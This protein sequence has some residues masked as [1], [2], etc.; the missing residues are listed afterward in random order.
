MITHSLKACTPD[1]PPRN[2]NCLTWCSHLDRTFETISV[3]FRDAPTPVVFFMVAVRISSMDHS[4]N[5]PRFYRTQSATCVFR[6]AGMAAPM[7]EFINM[8]AAIHKDRPEGARS[9]NS[10]NHREAFTDYPEM[11]TKLEW[12]GVIAEIVRTVREKCK[13]DSVMQQFVIA[14]SA[15]QDAAS[16]EFK[17]DL[18]M[19]NPIQLGNDYNKSVRGYGYQEYFDHWSKEELGPALSS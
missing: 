12:N 1:I 16:G 14:Y 8:A 2:P 4:K 18:F 11:P 10:T 7:E 6:R 5:T 9:R 3:E 19:T 13:H 17:S 15:W